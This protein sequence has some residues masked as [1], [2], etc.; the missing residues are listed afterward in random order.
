MLICLTS[1]ISDGSAESHQIE[2]W[3]QEIGKGDTQALC[4]L[5]EKTRTAVYGL[6]LSML[7]NPYDAEDILQDTFVQIHASAGRYQAKQ[8]PMAWI[9]TIAKNLCLRRLRDSQRTTPLTDEEWEKRWDSSG[10]LTPDDRL[11][12]KT[13]LK[14]LSLREQQVIGMHTAGLRHREIASYLELPLST[15]L[16]CYHRALKKLKTKLTEDIAHA[17]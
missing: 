2:G 5:Y 11:V 12:L 16:S 8:K 4:R 7:M 3:I 17:K 15:V 9:F 6:A 10:T 14:E 13:V 1:T